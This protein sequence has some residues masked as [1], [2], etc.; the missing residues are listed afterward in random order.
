MSTLGKI[1]LFINLLAAAGV[2]YLASDAWGQRQRLNAGLLKFGLLKDGF[3]LELAAG[4]TVN[5]GNDDEKVPFDIPTASGRSA[6]S[7][8]VK[9]LKEMFAGAKGL[10][11]DQNPPQSLIDEVKK[12]QQNFEAKVNEQQGDGEKLKFLIG[13]PDA[14]GR[15]IP[16]PLMLLADD[17]DERMLFRSWL[18]AAVRNPQEAGKYF[19]FAQK[20]VARKFNEAIAPPDKDAATR[21]V[22]AVLAARKAR[23]DAYDTWQKAPIEQQ[24]AANQAFLATETALAEKVTAPKTSTSDLERRRQAGVL[25]VCLDLSSQGQKRAALV[26][27]MKGYTAVIQDRV[28]R[29]QAMPE[30][31]ERTIESEL[32]QFLVKYEQRL[33]SAKG[34]DRLATKQK[35]NRVSLESTDAHLKKILQERITQRDAAAAEAT[36]IE[37]KVTAASATQA[38]IEQTLFGLQKQVGRLLNSN[39]ELED[40]LIQAERRLAG[41]K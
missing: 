34:L 7:V 32:T 12:I 14:G 33:A 29:L 15:L 28:T 13:A 41:S 22:E 2:A 16:G 27:G 25:M 38:D 5:M 36:A 17:F 19:A 39:F 30:R 1:L 18:D 26:L 10:Y 9:V 6:D 37:K 35:E 21:H 24:N 4:K 8:R 3:P 31:Y 11:T 23:D 20:A 40:Q